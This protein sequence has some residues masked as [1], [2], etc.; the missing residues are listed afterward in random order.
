MLKLKAVKMEPVLRRRKQHDLQ[1]LIE[2]FIKSG[3]DA[4]EVEFDIEHDYKS[5]S[6]C[7]ACLANA[8]RRSRRYGIKTIKNGNRV[9]LVKGS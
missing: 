8:I 4:M 6:V 1:S 2:E 7:R 9:F 3:C 5:A